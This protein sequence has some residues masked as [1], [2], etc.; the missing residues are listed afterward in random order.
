M[1]KNWVQIADELTALGRKQ[2]KA[3]GVA[4]VAPSIAPSR[5]TKEDPKS[6]D[7][8]LYKT[9]DLESGWRGDL[10]KH[11][12]T[13]QYGRSYDAKLSNFVKSKGGSD[14]DVQQFRYWLNK[15]TAG[16]KQTETIQH[17]DQVHQYMYDHNMLPNTKPVITDYSKQTSKVK[18]SNPKKAESSKKS[19]PKERGGLL[20]F[21][22]S[23]LGRAGNKATEMLFG[24]EFNDA[25]NK[26][27]EKTSKEILKKNPK[28]NAAKANLQINHNVTREAKNKT[29]KVSDFL[30]DTAGVMAPYTVGGAYG[31][32]G[33]AMSSIKALNAI[34]NPITKE[35]ARGLIAGTVAGSER[36]GLQSLA[37]GK[38]K[39][40]KEYAKNIAT[41]AAYAGG[42]DAAFSLAGMGIKKGMQVASEKAM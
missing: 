36:E 33:K 29:E 4:R 14:D 15:K 21:L 17:Q 18:T 26:Y 5:P 20:G 34:N 32:A 6:K 37:S 12:S 19:T 28:D 16:L 22:D 41:E 1:T 2:A 3:Q 13:K 24:K 11:L 27:Y 30:G 23:T 7:I 31:V 9:K 42:G 39:S 10:L 8:Y 25:Q 38:L 35:L 40:P